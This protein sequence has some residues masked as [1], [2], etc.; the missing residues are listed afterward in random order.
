VEEDDDEE[1]EE[2][3]DEGEDES[4]DTGKGRVSG[5]PSSFGDEMEDSD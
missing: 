1:D 2:E 4:A 3:D 5:V